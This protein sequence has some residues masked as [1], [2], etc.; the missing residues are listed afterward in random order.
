MRSNLYSS[1][2]LKRNRDLFIWKIAGLRK[3]TPYLTF[4]ELLTSRNVYTLLTLL[5]LLIKTSATSQAPLISWEKSIGGT[6]W[7]EPIGIYPSPDGSYIL[8]GRI[9]SSSGS[10]FGIAKID[11][12]GNVI[13]QKEYGGSI[14]EYASQFVQSPDGGY[15][16]AG[17]TYSEDGD[18]EGSHGGGDTWII[19]LDNAGNLLWQIAVGGSDW[20]QVDDLKPLADGGCITVGFTYSSDGDATGNKGAVDAFIV[21]IDGSGNLV[22][23]RTLGGSDWDWFSSVDETPDG[24]FIATGF[25]ASNDGDVVGNHGNSD[26]WTIKLDAAGNLLWQKAYGGSQD[27][28]GIRISPTPDGGYLLLGSTTSNDGNVDGHHGGGD[29]WMLKLNHKGN[30]VWQKTLGGS[31]YDQ[32]NTVLRTP[33][34]GYALSGYTESNDGDVSGNHGAGDIWIVRLNSSREIIWQKTLGGSEYETIDFNCMKLTPDNGYF[35]AGLT[36]STDGDVKGNHGKSDIWL[37]RLDKRG[38][39][40]WQKALGGSEDDGYS[41]LGPRQNRVLFIPDG[42]YMIAAASFSSDGDVTQNLGYSDIWLVKLCSEKDSDGDGI[43][44]SCDQDDD[45]DNDPDISDCAPLNPAVHHGA[46]EVCNGIDDD[47]NNEI[48]EGFDKDGDGYSVCN[49]D[50][51]DN[52]EDINP[53]TDWW[54]DDDGD[55]WGNPNVMV[56]GCRPPNGRWVMNNYD[57]NDIKNDT[58]KP[59]KNEVLMCRNN[60]Q[61]CVKA[62]E[63]EKKIEQGW[64]LGPCSAPCNDKVLMCHNGHLHCVKQ[65][66]EEKKLNKGWTRGYCGSSNANE[67]FSTQQSSKGNLYT[68]EFALAGYPNPFKNAVSIRYSVPEEAIISIKI[69][70]VTGREVGSVVNAKKAAGTY[71]AHFNAEA[72]GG[73]VYYFRMIAVSGK[74]RYIQTQRL[75]K[76]K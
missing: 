50:C 30:I 64:S 38:T 11:A 25:S 5:F 45:N 21:R 76:V 18:V 63:I 16:M 8:G 14:Y 41:G 17:L 36:Y 12:A 55:G 58:K 73:G 60:K 52:D 49:G 22:W 31:A 13:W 37:V 40:L 9:S 20:E 43:G 39:I 46:E 7:D 29:S 2:L 48:D 51:N 59:E 44:D 57:C 32:L 75:V 19:K 56:T 27:D 42:S 26:I 23:S 54:K 69:F 15:I 62:K 66:E 33:D 53:E 68:T 34:G 47:C 35:A 24:G 72:L 74:Q 6:N 71:N 61:E 65:K 1:L 3:T 10:K 70:D 4:S 67:R 28:L